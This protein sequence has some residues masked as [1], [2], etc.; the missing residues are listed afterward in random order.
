MYET[1]LTE[2]EDRLVTHHKRILHSRFSTVIFA[3]SSILV[4]LGTIWHLTFQNLLSVCVLGLAVSHFVVQILILIA[5]LRMKCDCGNIPILSAKSRM[6]HLRLEQPTQPLRE[7]RENIR[8]LTFFLL[9]FGILF[10]IC[11]FFSV[12]SQ[13]LAVAYMGLMTATLFGL[14]AVVWLKRARQQSIRFLSLDEVHRLMTVRGETIEELK[15]LV[16]FNL[17]IGNFRR[18]AEYSEKLLLLSEQNVA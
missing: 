15:E 7:L 10:C 9:Y 8:I 4:G 16:D 12:P 2:I 17:Y 6:Y 11:R 5:K 18:A 3:F 14:T 1:K 13:Y